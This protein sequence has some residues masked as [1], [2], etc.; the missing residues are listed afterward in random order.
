LAEVVF[1]VDRLSPPQV[2]ERIIDAMD[3]E[4]RSQ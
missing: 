2:V 1:D 4:V 3:Q